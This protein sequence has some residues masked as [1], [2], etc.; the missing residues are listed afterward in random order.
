MR[1]TEFLVIGCGAMGSAAAHHL[2]KRGR[3]PLVLEQFA[4]DHDRGSSHDFSRMI[5]YTYDDP[6]YVELMV[7]AYEHWDQLEQECGEKIVHRC[8]AINVCA[9]G[10]DYVSNCAAALSQF[11]I[12]H[13]IIDPMELQRRY[14]QFS[15]AESDRVMH[16]PEDGFLSPSLAVLQQAKMARRHSAEIV[17]DSAV[18]RIDLSGPHPVVHTRDER[19]ECRRLIVA[20][21]A[22]SSRLLADL[23]LPLVVTR[24][25]VVWLNS[26]D[27]D[28]FRP[29]RFPVFVHVDDVLMYGFPVFGREGLKAARHGLGAAVDPDKV[30]RDPS[31][32]YIETVRGFVRD[33]LPSGDGEP[34]HAQVCLY[35]ESPDSDFIIDRHPERED[36]VIAAGFTG[37]GFKFANLVGRLLA[38]MAEG[39]RIAWPIDRFSIRR[40]EGQDYSK[41]TGGRRLH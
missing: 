14:P 1:T 8:G 21:G 6:A 11:G 20:A 23:N 26:A 32:D 30:D 15:V 16:T 36:V 17:E 19:Y 35:T 29:D 13:E 39:E 38:D 33:F 7:P 40:F 34:L 24:Q 25:Q 2:A 9:A 5:R 3:R 4:I 22:W 12:E 10:N 27:L 18:E 31:P 28:A 37:H 41:L